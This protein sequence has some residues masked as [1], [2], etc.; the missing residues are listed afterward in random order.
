MEKTKIMKKLEI[1]TGN[2]QEFLKHLKSKFPLFHK[3]NIF[4]RDIEYGIIE[5]LKD[6]NIK[7]NY[8]EALELSSKVSEYLEKQN[9]FKRIDS[10]TWLL[11][12]EEFLTPKIEK[13][14][15][16]VAAKI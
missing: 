7:V 1:I 13:Q 6:K 4:L 5:Y 8:R 11:N 16:S 9:I 15:T 12:Y 14:S 10:K 2:Y 3:S